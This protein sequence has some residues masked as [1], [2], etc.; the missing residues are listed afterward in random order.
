MA[1][2]VART[3]SEGVDLK[4]LGMPKVGLEAIMADLRKLYRMA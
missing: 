3:Q 1:A 4:A 2:F